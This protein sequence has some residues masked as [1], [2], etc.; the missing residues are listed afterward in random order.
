M[1]SIYKLCTMKYINLSQSKSYATIIGMFLFAFLSTDSI[2]QK[3][4]DQKN[5]PKPFDYP[6]LQKQ[7]LDSDLDPQEFDPQPISLPNLDNTPVQFIN[8]RTDENNRP[9]WLEMHVAIRTSTPE[10][11]IDD[12]LSTI[13]DQFPSKSKD[14]TWKVKYSER[15]DLG[16][17]HW[18]L[19]EY[20]N[21]VPVYYNESVLHSKANHF[22]LWNGRFLDIK[23]N[24]DVEN[25]I[26]ERAAFEK[27][28]AWYTKNFQ[29]DFVESEALKGY[30]PEDANQGKLFLYHHNNSN[31][32]VWKFNAMP[33][34]LQRYE[35][36]VDAHSGKVIDHFKN[37]CGAAHHGAS[38]ASHS[39]C[40]HAMPPP[41]V[42]SGTDLLGI[43]RSLNTY[44]SG[45]RNYMID[46]SRSMFNAG[47]SSIPNDPKGVI[48]TLDARNTFPN[49]SFNPAQ[50]STTSNTWNNRTAVSA[51]YNAGR[52]FEYFQNTF[53]RN[54]I[55]GRGG[56]ILSYINVADES[57][58]DMDNAFWN[59]IAMFY[60]NG[61]VGFS[62][63]LSRSL[64]VAGH[65]MSHGVIQNTAN[66]EYR[67]ESGA[68]NESF[69]DVFGVMMDR[70][71]WQLGE[72]VVNSSVFRSGAL[73]DMSN[74]NNGG[75]SLNDNGYQPDHYN[76]RYTGSQDNGGVH[77]NSGIPNFAFFKIATDIGKSKAEEIF[78]RALTVGYLTRSSR[79]ID[80]RAAI[81]Q[82]ATDLY[83]N[84]ESGAC[85]RACDEVG[86]PGSSGGGGTDPGDYQNDLPVNPGNEF[87]V[88]ADE[89]RNDLYQLDANGTRRISSDGPAS[90]PSITDNGR[91]ITYVNDFDQVNYLFLDYNSG[92]ID[93]FILISSPE[94]DYVAFS[95]DG[96][97]L[98]GVRNVQENKIWVYDFNS[99]QWGEFTL[100]NPSYSEGVN[101]GDVLYADVLEWDYS[102]EY[103]MYDSYNELNSANG[104]D[105]SYWDIGFLKVWDNGSD[106]FDSD[107]E[108]FKLFPSLPEGV[109]IG[110]PTFS[111]NSPYI[112]AFDL[113]D[114]DGTNY[115][116]GAN[117][118]TSTSNAILSSDRLFYPTYGL[119]DN[120]LYF[121]YAGT[122]GDTYKIN[123]I[124]LNNDKISA[125]GGLLSAV[126]GARWGVIHGNGVRDLSTSSEEEGFVDLN[127]YPNPFQDF[128]KV[129]LPFTAQVQFTDVLGRTSIDRQINPSIDGGV[130][131]TFALDKGTY[132]LT[133]EMNGSKT[134]RTVT[135]K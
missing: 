116:I 3:G 22:Y 27:V 100:Y 85:H 125:T 38:C 127:I 31:H 78:Y 46:A 40:T 42:T 86:I 93:E 51:H 103:V 115:L 126:N 65:E 135:K 37:T 113:I 130:I 67:N 104:E 14:L 64:D 32:V 2:A 33:N 12:I 108:I 87:L 7:V 11:K 107:G 20:Y 19:Q 25:I 132:F 105:I 129:A 5:D 98:A 1:L 134:V 110:N 70:D 8:E 34:A 69:A 53:N 24:V 84:T 62:S 114:T 72:E 55:D 112:I 133:I 106:N 109:S 47:A 81:A 102:G 111:K 90:K 17:T 120:F 124:E 96:S 66:L 6:Q 18:Y 79:F 23:E 121:D 118:E 54:S 21:N 117:L 68:L 59:G 91:E 83:G 48:W 128:V 29:Q 119:M 50:V 123:A 99:S 16:I 73:R 71:D 122:G 63:P 97:K 30:M 60:G 44:S 15:D 26:T 101:T 49:N 9:E 76:Q 52:A 61:D 57:G 56:R 35:V 74:P 82:A 45:G 4:S 89:D 92:N 36:F 75:N 10:E 39:E 88:L 95:K 77:I 28:K 13:K 58:R 94:W 80:F 131:N 41:N 43:N